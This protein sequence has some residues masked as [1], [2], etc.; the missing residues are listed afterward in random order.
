MQKKEKEEREHFASLNNFL[1][2]GKLEK[3]RKKRVDESWNHE[4]IIGRKMFRWWME[5]KENS[6]RKMEEVGFL[7]SR[8]ENGNSYSNYDW[9]LLPRPRKRGVSLPCGEGFHSVCSHLL[10]RRVCVCVTKTRIHANWTEGECCSSIHTRI[11]QVCCIRETSF[12]LK[13]G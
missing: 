9:C 3:A 11:D 4:W 1:W 10:R 7:S 5:E 2:K 6:S 8:F 12:C 13:R